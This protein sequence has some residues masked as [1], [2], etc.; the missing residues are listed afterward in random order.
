MIS[1]AIRRGEY[2]IMSYLLAATVL[3]LLSGPVNAQQSPV[4]ER[5]TWTQGDT[6]TYSDP[7]YHSVKYTVLAVTPDHYTAEIINK[8]DRRVVTVDLDLHPNDTTLIQFQ[9]PLSQ[10]VTWKRTLTG[11]GPDGPSS[12]EITSYVEAYEAVVTPAGSFDAFRIKGYHCSIKYATCGDFSTWYAPSAK[13]YVKISFG[14]GY[15]PAALRGNSRML[16]S[17]Q[18]H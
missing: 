14:P 17:Y 10:G 11:L 15:W 2:V 18:V 8:T 4:A 13:F 7:L 6:W 16:T 5:P 3:L 12:W 9:W 1:L